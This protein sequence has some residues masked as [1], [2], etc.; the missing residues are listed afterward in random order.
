MR[1]AALNHRDHFI[2]R[3]LYPGIGFGTALLADGV[4]V[5]E[6]LGP[7]CSAGAEAAL[8]GRRVI[9]TPSRGWRSDP[10]GPEDPSRFAVT[11]GSR[12]LPDSGTA[13]HW[14]VVPE[15]ELGTFLVFSAP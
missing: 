8:L 4:G 3:H 5:V 13:R 6:A 14:A 7:A 1:A 15:D 9:P 2:R 12:A 11:G 10:R